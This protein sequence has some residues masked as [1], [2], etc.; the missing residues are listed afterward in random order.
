MRY[1]AQDTTA[2]RLATRIA[3]AVGER[4]ADLVIKNAQIL[5][6]FTGTFFSGDVA[7]ADGIV[8]GTQETYEGKCELDAQG[9]FVVPGFIDA[10][11]HIE[12]CLMTPIRFQECVLPRGTTTALWDPHEIANVLGREGVRWALDCADRTLIDIFVL[13]PSCVPATHLE[14]SGAGLEAADLAIFKNHPKVLGLA[15]VMNVPGV[16]HTDP[17]LTAKLELFAGSIRD[18]HA[19]LLRGRALNCYLCAGIQGCHESSDLEEAREKLRKGMHVL[20]REGSC[21]KNAHDL[22]PLIDAYT[23]AT[24]A[25]CSDDRNPADIRTEGH[26]DFIINTGLKAGLEPAQIFRSASFAAARAYGLLDRG[27]LAPGYLGDAVVVRQRQT[28]DWLQ[29]FD[30]VHVI[31]SGKRVDPVQLTAIAVSECGKGRPQGKAQNI[32]LRMPSLADMR[33]QVALPQGFEPGTTR[34]A[35]DASTS[36]DSALC[37]VIGV[38]PGQILTR[39]LLETLPIQEGCIEASPSQDVLKIG[40][41]ERHHASGNK[42][43]GFV[44]GFG[45][46]EGALASSIGHDSHNIVAIGATDKALLAA[47]EAI[48]ALDGGIVVVD[49]SGQ[50]QAKLALPIAGLMTDAPPEEV[51]SAISALKFQARALGCLLDEPFLLMSFLALPVI[52]EL[53]ITDL[54]LVDVESFSLVSVCAKG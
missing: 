7:F 37:R 2:A 53:K 52:P 31:K 13:L 50:V 33:I 44:K 40:V 29:G 51:A 20:I 38:M 4:P 43:L 34:E 18:G 35:K 10:H 27:V 39:A 41:F 32:N 5:D 26:I 36:P 46:R 16:L 15:E 9:M 14:T 47:I 25:L 21:A 42:G 49:A 54:G 45:L 12:S 30:V 48:V 28:G 3:V 11:V 19:P 6:V 1:K 24:V 22:L 17:G 23:S 8:V